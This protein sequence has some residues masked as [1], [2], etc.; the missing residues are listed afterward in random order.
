M[1][2]L[3]QTGVTGVVL[4]AGSGSRMGTPKALLA[5]PDGEPWVALATHT[6]RAAGCAHVIVVL[7]AQADAA[8]EFVPEGA[9]VVL[10]DDW[11]SGMAAS[12]HAGLAAASHPAM[13]AAAALVTLV[14]LPGLTIPAAA[15]VLGVDAGPDT[16]RRAVFDG[17]PGHPVLVGRDHWDALAGTLGGDT[18]AQVYL[19]EHGVELVE[20]SDLWDGA[21]VDL[22]PRAG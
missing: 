1:G 14:D 2:E 10:A 4:A 18:G 21:D 5:T 19:R 12:L 11:R 9:H 8:L 3:T 17:R 13:H 7:G 6:L 16:L 15:R 22:S 20:C